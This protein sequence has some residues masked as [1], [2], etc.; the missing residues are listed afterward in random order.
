MKQGSRG[1]IADVKGHSSM[2]LS[3]MDGL[4]AALGAVV[5]L[6]LDLST[7][8]SSQSSRLQEDKGGSY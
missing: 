7:A 4:L 8:Y 2:A 1:G 6:T 5:V 3:R